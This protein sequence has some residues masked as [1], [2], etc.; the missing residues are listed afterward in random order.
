MKLLGTLCAVIPAFGLLAR[1]YSLTDNVV[2]SDFYNVFD[3]ETMADPS[4]GRV[5]FLDQQTS[6]SRN[7][8]YATSDTFILRADFQTVLD[9]RGPGRDSFRIKS[10]KSY[11]THVAVFDIRHM[12]EGCAT[13]PAIWE[14]KETE[15]PGS[16]EVDIVEGIN[17]HGP[18]L[19]ALHTAQ[20]CSMPSSRAQSGYSG[21]QD[22][23][24][25]PADHTGCTVHYP[26]A[27]SFGPS[28]NSAGGGWYAF[29]RAQDHM[30]VWFWSR[31]DGSVPGEVKMGRPEIN[32]SN[33][34]TPT[35]F[36][37]NTSCDFSQ[38]FKEHNIIINLTLCGD[39]AGQFF[40][41]NGCPGQCADYVNNNP[42]AFRNAYF[43]FA[44]M[45]V[46]Q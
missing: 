43:E 24:T 42:A 36:F 12:P 18:N 13:W 32:P 10:K 1:A 44:S 3:W 35:A 16:G 26:T 15:W 45:R 40:N 38:H 31:N 14:V 9:P 4:N 30:K 19:S 20:G 46:Y 25:T 34:G 28:F 17:D 22:C 7:L 39:W 33:W 41:Q 27:N 6:K 23:S 5:Q 2:G 21:Q 8:T 37:P 29:E 11:T